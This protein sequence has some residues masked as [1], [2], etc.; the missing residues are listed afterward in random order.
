M[1]GSAEPAATPP[2]SAPPAYEEG[3]SRFDVLMRNRRRLLIG[4]A[5]ILLASAVA[6]GSTAV[7]TS[8]DANAGNSFAAGDLEVNAPNEA[9]FTATNMSPGDTETGTATIENTGSVSGDFTMSAEVTDN[10]PGPGGGSLANVLEV[11]VTDGA[12]VV[13][14]T[15]SFAGMQD[16]DLG[17]WIG[18][19]GHTYDFTVEF[20][21]T[22]ENQN[23]FE[24]ASTTV[25]FTWD[26][27]SN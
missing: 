9:I 19:E 17:S 16:V 21:E 1:K 23:Q 24:G 6:V 12:T 11:T 7:F 8:S 2:S 14:P 27:V 13:Y 22:G 3:P 4:L 25:T 5:L 15:G 10:T 18:G 26:A 20:P